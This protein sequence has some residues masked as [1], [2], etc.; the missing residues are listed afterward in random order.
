VAD[1]IT[2]GREDG[3]ADA[4]G[5]LADDD[6][7]LV[8]Y[9]LVSV[10][11][12]RER[13][14]PESGDTI[15]VTDNMTDEGFTN[16][17]VGRFLQKQA[18]PK[19]DTTLEVLDSMMRVLRNIAVDPADRALLASSG[20]LIA[21]A[22]ASEQRA[23]AASREDKLTAGEERFLRVHFAVIRRWPREPLKFEE[24]QQEVLEQVRDALEGQRHG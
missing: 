12:G 6:V 4:S 2:G 3:G 22:R 21:Q 19:R 17:A 10:K 20:Q 15:I 9:F 23:I 1:W 24:Q 16:Y 13:V 14:I 7:K 5:P 8:G 11:R 18:Q